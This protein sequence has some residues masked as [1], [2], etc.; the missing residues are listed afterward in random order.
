MGQGAI[1]DLVIFTATNDEAGAKVIA[2][3]KADGKV[4]NETLASMMK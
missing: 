2:L 3:N 1:R 4:V